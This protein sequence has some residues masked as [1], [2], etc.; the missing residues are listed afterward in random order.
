MKKEE[1][2]ITEDV[3]KHTL[4]L[5][6]CEKRFKLGGFCASNL[7]V[8]QVPGWLEN[9]LMYSLHTLIPAENVKEETYI[10]KDKYPLDWKQAFKEQHFPTWLKKRYPVKYK[11]ITKTVKFTAYNIYPK[12]PA[13][14]PEQCKDAIQIIT[15]NREETGCGKE[16]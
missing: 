15:M 6:I 2:I 7:T 5:L 14:Y 9:E 1:D 11:E 8:K 13:M 16:K 10:F 12:F 3:V 4:D